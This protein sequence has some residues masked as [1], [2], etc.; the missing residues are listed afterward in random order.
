M[1]RIWDKMH[2]TKIEEPSLHEVLARSYTK[3]FLP[4]ES[5]KRMMYD[6]RH[7]RHDSLR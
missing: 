7:L 3:P 5:T 1:I 2:D 4:T 6:T